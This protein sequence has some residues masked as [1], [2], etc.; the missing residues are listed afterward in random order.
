MATRTIPEELL[1]QI[2]QHI[3]SPYRLEPDC[4]WFTKNCEQMRVRTLRNICLAS[5]AC[6]RIASPILYKKFM[7]FVQTPGLLHRNQRSILYLKSIL[8][9]P[10]NALAL[11][12]LQLPF[13]FRHRDT[14]DGSGDFCDLMAD[15]SLRPEQKARFKWIV[16]VI[17]SRSDG[18]DLGKLL[19]QE[20]EVAV[21]AMILLHCPNITKLEMRMPVP[22]PSGVFCIVLPIGPFRRQ[23]A[24]R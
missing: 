19:K 18:N 1:Q 6:H 14:R 13:Q 8:S 24:P 22:S 10:Q 9:N 17:L 4:G 23:H 21:L 16:Q 15:R 5:R 3:D 20:W 12:H 11:E 7:H 2:F